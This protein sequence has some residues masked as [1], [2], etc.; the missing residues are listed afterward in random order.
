M[1]KEKSLKVIVAEKKKR[2][3]LTK[4][5]EKRLKELYEKYKDKGISFSEL[6]RLTGINRGSIANRF[7]KWKLEEL[8]QENKELKEK[9]QELYSK[10]DSLQ[11]EVSKKESVI[12]TKEAVIT[13]LED[14]LKES[15]KREKF[16]LFLFILTA[17][18]AVVLL[19]L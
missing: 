13:T 4:E 11:K 6:E 12:T 17:L 2:K 7:Q 16:F 8:Q 19:V 15:R 5:E 10:I 1:K 3:A 14:E 9:V 18:T